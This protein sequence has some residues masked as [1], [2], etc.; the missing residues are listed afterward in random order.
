MLLIFSFFRKEQVDKP[1]EP[2]NKDTPKQ[3]NINTDTDKLAAMRRML[4]DDSGPDVEN[5]KDIDKNEQDT[6]A[7]NSA[8][9][10]VVNNFIGTEIEENNTKQYKNIKPMK[11]QNITPK[12]NILKDTTTSEDV[13]PQEKGSNNAPSTEMKKGNNHIKELKTTPGL[14]SGWQKMV[15]QNSG[16][17]YYIDHNTKTTHW[18]LPDGIFNNLTSK[19][20]VSKPNHNNIQ[21]SS[22]NSARK[23]NE[24]TKPNA[25]SGPSQKKPNELVSKI[26]N[27]AVPP[28]V[29][30]QKPPPST[31]LPTSTK[32]PIVGP[33]LNPPQQFFN[34]NPQ[35]NQHTIQK[36]SG[37]D[38]S[39]QLQKV[40]RPQQP[41]QI[42]Q[43]PKQ[44]IIPQ[45]PDISIQPPPAQFSTV[46]FHKPT[47]SLQPQPSVP[48][49]EIINKPP[50][51]PAVSNIPTQPKSHLRE[52]QKIPATSR[53][54]KNTMDVPKQ[55]SLKRSLSSPNLAENLA[56]IKANKPKTPIVDRGSKPL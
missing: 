15:D 10:P 2:P 6:K 11:E 25:H 19:A 8:I 12:N 5:M 9:K 29:A 39:N 36:P 44:T 22:N 14:P 7:I 48:R 47:V 34:P 28:V 33:V 32:E 17:V 4:S 20:T 24:S 38:V 35:N 55:P 31:T 16:K 30:T 3:I 42:L 1:P 45:T 26:P 18:A 41:K 50:N 49:Q 21:P 27:S 54:P 51:R 52:E 13:G 53:V 43:T 40:V 46:P 56:N 23:Q 37:E